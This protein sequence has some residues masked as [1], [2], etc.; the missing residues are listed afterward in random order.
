V[1]KEAEGFWDS[2]IERDL[3]NVSISVTR[4][5]SRAS[6]RRSVGLMVITTAAERIAMIPMTIR[7]SM[8]VKAFWCIRVDKS[9][10]Y[11][12]IIVEKGRKERCVCLSH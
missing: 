12:C 6:R 5:A 7:S 11:Y 10:T 9:N 3:F 4:V 8:R 2:K 1:P